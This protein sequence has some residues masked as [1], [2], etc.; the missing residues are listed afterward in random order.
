MLRGTGNKD[1]TMQHGAY[2]N[3]FILWS[4]GTSTFFSEDTREQVPQWNVSLFS[5]HTCTFKVREA[6]IL[7]L[8]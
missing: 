5:E 6:K 7:I 3:I 4:R 2:D 1:N 8:H